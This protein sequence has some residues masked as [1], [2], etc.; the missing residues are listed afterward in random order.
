MG[1]KVLTLPSKISGNF[2]K[3]GQRVPVKITFDIPEKLFGKIVPGLSVIVSID[4][5]SDPSV[6]LSD[7]NF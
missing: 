3:V 6:N 1:C 4:T 7:K 5:K 2:V